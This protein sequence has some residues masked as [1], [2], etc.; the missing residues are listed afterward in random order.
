MSSQKHKKNVHIELPRFVK[1]IELVIKTGSVSN[2]LG[3]DLMKLVSYITWSNRWLGDEY[4]SD[5]MFNV[6]NKMNRLHKE[7]ERLTL[8]GNDDKQVLQYIKN[9]IRFSSLEE[10]RKIDRARKK[11]VQFEPIGQEAL[12]VAEDPMAEVLFEWKYEKKVNGE[13]LDMYRLL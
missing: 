5:V 3:L 2:R 9:M 13:H 6:L 7:P 1:D 11:E 4:E 12:N 8:E 10:R